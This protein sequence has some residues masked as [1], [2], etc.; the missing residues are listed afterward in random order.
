VELSEHRSRY[1]IGD[2]AKLEMEPIRNP[3]TGDEALPSVH[4]PQGLVFNE[5]HYATS[6]VFTVSDGV[7][8]DHSGKNT[9]YAPF[10]YSG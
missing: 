9:E 3:V 10:S 8:Y 4:L 5:G 1:T 6:S 7:H 2:V